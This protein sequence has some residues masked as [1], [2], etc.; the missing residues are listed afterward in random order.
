[1]L[2]KLRKQTKASQI[3]E[4]LRQDILRGY[5]APGT[6]LQLENLK[7]KYGVGFS[8]LREALSRLITNGL[9]HF[10]EQCGFCV[11]TLSLDELYDIYTNR[12]R[13]ENI[14]LELAIE[15]GD[16][17][18]EAEIIACWYRYSK[19][20]KTNDTLDSYTWHAMEKEFS[21]TLIKACKSPW[22]LKMKDILYENAARY[23]FLCLSRHNTNR[24]TIL[25]YIH[26]CQDLVNAVIARDKIK[27]LEI[28]NRAWQSSIQIMSTELKKHI[29]LLPHK[30]FV[31]SLQNMD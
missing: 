18:W 19:F 12:M 15:N 1:M 5:F 23:H 7:Q 31:N 25:A 10:K 28:S 16:D 20:M 22:L 9:V 26:D 14:A 8:P 17:H 29:H 30:P 24:E 13:I 27:S 21:S 2:N 3:T 11:P 4:K 6:K